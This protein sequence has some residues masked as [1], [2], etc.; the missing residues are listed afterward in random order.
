MKRK[1]EK[2]DFRVFSRTVW[3]NKKKYYIRFLFCCKAY[4]TRAK[5]A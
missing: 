2:I 1:Q 4:L 5:D 3:G